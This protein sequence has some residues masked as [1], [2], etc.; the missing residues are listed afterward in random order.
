MKIWRKWKLEVPS[1]YDTL[2]NCVR[3]RK[4]R[5]RDG[6]RGKDGRLR[7]IYAFYLILYRT[8]QKLFG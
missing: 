4:K 2:L 1:K 3:E 6:K 5:E 8:L 7:E